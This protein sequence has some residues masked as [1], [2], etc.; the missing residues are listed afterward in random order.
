MSTY[1]EIY[2]TLLK[3]CQKEGLRLVEEHLGYKEVDY[4]RG[5]DR[6]I[7]NLDYDFDKTT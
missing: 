6:I 2:S 3:V 7:L 5:D 1:D 4:L